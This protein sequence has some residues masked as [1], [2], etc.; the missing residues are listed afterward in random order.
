MLLPASLYLLQE[1][2]VSLLVQLVVFLSMALVIPR[3]GNRWFGS[4]S[5]SLN[6]SVVGALGLKAHR[7]EPS[8][9]TS[10]LAIERV[11]AASIACLVLSFGLVRAAQGSLE[12]AAN[13]QT[14]LAASSQSSLQA[15]VQKE[16]LE[17]SSVPRQL[18]SFSFVLLQGLLVP[19]AEELVYRGLV[20]QALRRRLARRTAIGLASVLFGLAHLLVYQTAVYQTILLGLSFGLAYESAGILASILTHMLWNL[21]LIL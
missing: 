5:A 15:F 17:T 14:R 19:V 6:S 21:W 18:P 10:R 20:Q 9:Q 4:E 8:W 1:Q 7:V 16:R 13:L 12:L 11:A 2:R 3:V